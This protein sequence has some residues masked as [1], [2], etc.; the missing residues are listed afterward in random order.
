[1]LTNALSSSLHGPERAYA[2]G[3]CARFMSQP[4]FTKALTEALTHDA[5]QT[6]PQLV[7]AACATQIPCAPEIVQIAWKWQTQTTRNAV[8]ARV[9]GESHAA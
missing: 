7:Y 2:I 8:Q 9:A 3:A 1:M 5:A 4:A 6:L